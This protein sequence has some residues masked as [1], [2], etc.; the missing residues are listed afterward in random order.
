MIDHIAAL[1]A[2]ITLLVEWACLRAEMEGML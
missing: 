1:L 2:I